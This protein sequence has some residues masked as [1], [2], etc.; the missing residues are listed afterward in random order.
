[1][2]FPDTK[3]CL[4]GV[5]WHQFDTNDVVGEDVT[6]LMITRS[7][8]PFVFLGRPDPPVDYPVRYPL[9]STP[10]NYHITPTEVVA[11]TPVRQICFSEATLVST[12]KGI[13]FRNVSTIPLVCI[14]TSYVCK[15]SA[16]TIPSIQVDRFI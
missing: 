5:K 7:S 1:M 9:L 10:R 2:I 15:T 14:V 11:D 4:E 12:V 6:T 8:R 3:G 13:P 16:V